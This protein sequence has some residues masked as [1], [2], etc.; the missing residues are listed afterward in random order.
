MQK[1]AIVQVS[2]CIPP[3]AGHGHAQGLEG[4][5]GRRQRAFPGTSVHFLPVCLSS[6]CL[7]LPLMGRPCPSLLLH[8]SR[9]RSRLDLGYGFFESPPLCPRVLEHHLST[10]R[11]FSQPRAARES[12]TRLGARVSDALVSTLIRR[13]SASLKRLLVRPALTRR[14]PHPATKPK[15]IIGF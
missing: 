12:A 15:G 6:S 9:H 3:F 11:T 4:Q 7:A 2:L 10:R 13:P 8:R 5:Q 1:P 14:H